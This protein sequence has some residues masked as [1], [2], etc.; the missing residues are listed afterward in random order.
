MKNEGIIQEIP[1]K[2]WVAAISVGIIDGYAVEDLNY[3]LDSAAETDMNIV[4][5]ES[6]RFVEIQGTAEREPFT[7]EQLEE[8]LSLAEA[9][10]TELIR[11]QK[12]CVGLI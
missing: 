11:Y 5:T 7:K 8:L 10:I 3:S 6:G 2:E 12:K 1:L 4:M 9:N